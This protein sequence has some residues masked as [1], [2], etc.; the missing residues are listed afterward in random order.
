MFDSLD[1]VRGQAGQQV[2]PLLFE[3]LGPARIIGHHGHLLFHDACY[4]LF[5][6]ASLRPFIRAPFLGSRTS[7]PGEAADSSPI[8]HIGA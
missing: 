6:G 7:W 3:H 1:K 2:K 4:L 5:E 8:V